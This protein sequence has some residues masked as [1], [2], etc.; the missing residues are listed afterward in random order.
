[1]YSKLSS[2]PIGW[3][4][5]L[6][7]KSHT[8][9]QDEIHGRGEG[10]CRHCHDHFGGHDPLLRIYLPRSERRERNPSRTGWSIRLISIVGLVEFCQEE[11]SGQSSNFWKGVL[12]RWE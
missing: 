6:R 11:R 1:M 12:Q 8:G 9:I 5:N 4:E 3:G 7:G 2:L 10:H